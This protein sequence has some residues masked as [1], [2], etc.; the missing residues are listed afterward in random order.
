MTI[1]TGRVDY[2]GIDALLADEERLSRDT[3]ARLVDREVIP[4]IG[5]AWL[6]GEFPRDLVQKLGALRVFGANLPQEYG[7]A[8]MTNLGYG[9]I[10]QELERG[11]SGLRSFASVQGA[12]V[13]YPIHAYGSEAQRRAWL[14]ALAA[15]ERIGCFGLT[16]PTSGSDPGAMQTR[17]RRT[18]GGWVLDGTKMWITNGSIADVA[19][20]WAKTEDG[21]I[22]GF[23]VD[24]TTPGFSANDIHTKAS[25]RA[26]VTSELVLENVRVR[27]EDVLPGAVGLGKALSC[28][29]QARYSIAW[30]AVGAAIACYEEALA[31]ARERVAFGRPIAATQIIQER[32]ANMLTSITTAQLLAYHLA[33]LKDA[34]TM[35]FTHVS[36][37]KRHNVR[38][39]LGVA[40]EARTILGGYGITLEYHAM[41]HAANL[42]SVD[43][44]EGTYDIHTLILGRDI[45]GIDAFG[46][47]QS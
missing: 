30:G 5:R 10:M 4:R 35:R 11:D 13:M 34:G 24:P 40:R 32:L 45:T 1:G 25:M 39:A 12:L 26:S 19:L 41:R 38:V 29:T 23:L 16:E 21:E 15:G 46:A 47:P 37:A 7:C 43:T 6:A 8:G 2:F 36:M 44:Y 31:Y 3:V 28:L 42:E 27:D 20:V 22:R 9:L 18:A 14:P 33:R 17:A